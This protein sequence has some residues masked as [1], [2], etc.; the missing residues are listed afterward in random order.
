MALVTTSKFQSTSPVWRTTPVTGKNVVLPNIFQST[1]PVW[2]TTKIHH[3]RNRRLLFQSTSPVWRTTADKRPCPQ[4]QRFQSTSPVWRTTIKWDNR[5][6]RIIN[7]NPRPPCG[8]RLLVRFLLRGS[9]GFQST[10]P[11]W[12]T[13]LNSAAVDKKAEISIH[14]PRVEDDRTTSLLTGSGTNFNPRPPCGG[15]RSGIAL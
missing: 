2:R 10:S 1:S 12:R 14:V 5:K 7:F 4:Y 11:V 3:E 8:G 6:R 15:R 9:H 13:T